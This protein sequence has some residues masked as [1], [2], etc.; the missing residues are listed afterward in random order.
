M[1]PERWQQVKAIFDE[2]AD[3]APA[4]RVCR[5]VEACGGDQTLIEEVDSLLRSHDDA[6]DFI[7]SS[8]DSNSGDFRIGVS[9]GPYRIVQAI[10]EGGMGV[11]Y[12]AVRVDDL[13]RKLVALK[14]VR[15]GLYSAT[16]MRRFETE[17]HIL[18]HLD[19]PNVAKLLDG[20][21]TPDGQPY[22]VMDFIAGTPIDTYCE[23]EKLP[24][25]QRLDLFL[26]VCSAVQYAHQNFIVHRD[27]KPSNILVTA[28]G[29]VRLL[30]FGI[31]K[32]LD[33]DAL[34][35]G[36]PGRDTTS[37]FQMMTPE[38][39]SPEQLRGLP[40]TTASDTWSLGVLLYV[41]LTGKKPFEFPSRSIHDIYAVI[42]DTEP[43]RPSLLTV[44]FVARELRGDLDNILLMSLR[45]EPERRYASVQQFAA[46]IE[47]YLTGMPVS[48]REDTFRYRAG[49]FVRRHK[50]AVLG[51]G[52]AA[53]ALV[54]GS[55]TTSL[56]AREARIERERAER[57][58][59]DVRRVTNSLLFDVP[60]A[61]RNLPGSG[62]AR[63]MIVT[64]ALDFLN[65]LAEDARTDQ[66]LAAELAKAW[67]RVGD[68]QADG[69]VKGAL[70]SY[71]HALDLREKAL[72]EKA[73][74]QDLK[75]ETIANYGKLADLLQV[76]G[77]SAASIE[78][79]RKSLA[80][81]EEVAAAKDALPED[82]MRL[83]ANYL[84]LGVKTR[85]AEDCRSALRLFE[86]MIRQE[87][88]AD[89][90][91]SRLYAVARERTA[92]VENGES[93]R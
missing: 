31:A 56:E 57:R 2:V 72:A 60:D 91:L 4:E 41:M 22:F 15:R 53:L 8:P 63:Q 75:R 49:K 88:G 71:R 35:G 66:G 17:R 77:A 69:D 59:N 73:S 74:D 13:Y 18:A 47:R 39:A 67:E 70:A 83:A 79:A 86:A 34:S 12:Q 26:T 82:R 21:T 58:F 29:A 46:D 78:Y 89:P 16:A 48:A 76:S 14:V 28:E 24:L 64:R 23:A 85:D 5:I 6:G 50:G 25:R 38:F 33:P 65:R 62:P 7:E 55:I 30:D 27:I 11:V 84:D 80:L 44:G 68:V 3:L 40:V 61:I 37:G 20:G 54:A 51:A 10:G 1:T 52:L 19:H 92:E 36:D 90:R 81:S 93:K 9:I 32:L 42:R 45:R 43:R 87:G